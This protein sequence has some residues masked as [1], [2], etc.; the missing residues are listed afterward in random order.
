VLLLFPG[1]RGLVSPPPSFLHPLIPEGNLWGQVTQK[2]VQP[3][4]PSCHQS[5]CVKPLKEIQ[6]TDP[7]H[8]T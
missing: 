6:S 1:E 4:R 7:N 5:N 3:G 2:F 8:V